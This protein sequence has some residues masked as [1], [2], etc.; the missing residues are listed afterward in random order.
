M[1]KPI[2]RLNRVNESGSETQIHSGDYDRMV[3]AIIQ[4][5]LNAIRHNCSYHYRLIDPEGA[6]RVEVHGTI[7]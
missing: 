5:S 1:A 2:F 6:V 3:D 4:N 7:R